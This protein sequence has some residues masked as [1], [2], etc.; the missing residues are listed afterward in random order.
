MANKKPNLKALQAECDA[1]NAKCPIGGPVR[2]KVDGSDK[3]RYTTTRSEAQIMSGHSAVV[4]MNGVSGSYL[5][6]HVTPITDA[7]AKLGAMEAESD[8][9]NAVPEKELSRA[10][11]DG[12]R[13]VPVLPTPDQLRAAMKFTN[14]AELAKSIYLAMTSPAALSVGLAQKFIVKTSDGYLFPYKGDV[15][16]TADIKKAGKFDSTAEADD[17]AQ[18]SLNYPA[19]SYEVIPVKQL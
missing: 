7:E 18:L 1:F 16:W 12:W 8:A 3:P 13:N 4:W 10:A 19:G 6:S 9:A 2:L 14:D 17:T 11:P 15:S 5:L